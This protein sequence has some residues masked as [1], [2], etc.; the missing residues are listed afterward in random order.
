MIFEAPLTAESLECLQAIKTVGS[1]LKKA[2]PSNIQNLFLNFIPG[3]R[4]TLMLESFP[5]SS[6]FFNLKISNQEPLRR[7]EI[8]GRSLC[9]SCKRSV[10]Y[11]CYRC[12]RM[13]EALE[14]DSIPQVSLPINMKM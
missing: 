11:F 4:E 10:K 6:P 14:N 3:T 5:T 8:D 13:V 9:S 1:S 7:A 2:F 12:V